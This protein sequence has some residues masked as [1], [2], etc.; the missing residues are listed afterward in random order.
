MYE[1]ILIFNN[2]LYNR[3]KDI[4]LFIVNKMKKN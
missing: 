4:F 1:D 3:L 2:E